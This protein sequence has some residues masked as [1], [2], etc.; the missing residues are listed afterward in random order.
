MSDV[1]VRLAR[2]PGRKSIVLFSEGL[3]VSPRLE[4]VVA[5]ALAENVTVYTVYAG[6]LNASGRFAVQD[7]TVDSGELTST[8]QRGRESW[9]YGFLAMDPTAGLGPFAY[10]TGGFLVSDTNDLSGALKS[11]N[12]DRRAYYVLAYSSSNQA[13]DRTTRKIEVRV[14]HPSLSVRARTAYVAAPPER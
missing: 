4:S 6:G 2:F 11:I 12:A 9:R 7:R 10:H 5:R 8:N 3:N 13:L 14:K 1:I